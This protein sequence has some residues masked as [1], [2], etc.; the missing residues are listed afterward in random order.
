MAKN[1][2]ELS[3]NLDTVKDA[4]SK[5]AR[6]TEKLDLEIADY[7]ASLAELRKARSLT[8]TQLA[9]QLNVKQPQVSRIEKQADLY[10]STLKSYLDAMGCKLEV[11]AI[12]G[13]RR[14]VLSLSSLLGERDAAIEEELP[15]EPNP[16]ATA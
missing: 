3:R 9:R 5:R 11:A 8:Q 14:I 10:L 4:K 15:S 7:E 16:L 1:F 12:H 13:D 6:A 2:S